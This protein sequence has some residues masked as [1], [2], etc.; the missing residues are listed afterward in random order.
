MAVVGFGGCCCAADWVG[1]LAGRAGIP[2][3]TS[4]NSG[5]LRWRVSLEISVVPDSGS[6]ESLAGVDGVVWGRELDL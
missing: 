3:V 1:I 4:R 2:L 5:W 6:V